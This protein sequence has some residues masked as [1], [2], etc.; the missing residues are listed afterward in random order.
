M[1]LISISGYFS[2]CTTSDV[3]FSVLSV[4]LFFRLG[5]HVGAK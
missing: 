4:V 3:F 1:T 2:Q 5:A